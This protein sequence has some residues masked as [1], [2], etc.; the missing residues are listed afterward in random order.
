MII[1][2]AIKIKG[3][4]KVSAK[5]CPYI[6]LSIPLSWDPLTDSLFNIHLK[7]VVFI[8]DLNILT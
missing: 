4:T 6:L 2:N 7:Q 1:L 5:Y 3:N 8:C